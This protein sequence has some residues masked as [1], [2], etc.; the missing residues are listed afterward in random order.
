LITAGDHKNFATGGYG[1][2]VVR[3]HVVPSS[4]PNEYRENADECLGWAKTARS[5][6]ERRIFLQMAEAWLAV[7]ARRDAVRQKGGPVSEDQLRQPNIS[8]FFLLATATPANV[9]ASL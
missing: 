3:E 7:A 9:S 8:K 4:K 6:R 5:D 1:G 2:P